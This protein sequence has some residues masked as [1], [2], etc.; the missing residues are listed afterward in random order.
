MRDYQP[1]VNNPYYIDKDIYK[2]ILYIIRSYNSQIK[3]YKTLI[4]EKAFPKYNPMNT[5]SKTNKT[6][7]ITGETAIKLEGKANIIKAIDKAIKT[8][9]ESETEKYYFK[10]IWNSI[11]YST[12]YPDDA[13]TSTYKRHKARFIWLVGKN[14]NII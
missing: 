10:G 9:E 13:S 1:K 11:I 4:D 5:G 3:E 6:S 8:F 12:P 2:S 14:L 7:D